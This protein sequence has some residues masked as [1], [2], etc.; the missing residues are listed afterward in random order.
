[1]ALRL[2]P[3]ID[4]LPLKAIKAQAAVK[5]MLHVGFDVSLY[6]MQRFADSLVEWDCPRARQSSN[7]ADQKSRQA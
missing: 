6:V 5:E 4:R 3:F 7:F 1:M 2:F